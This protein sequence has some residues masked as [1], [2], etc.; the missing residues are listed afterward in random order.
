M[1]TATICP[2]CNFNHDGPVDTCQ[3]CGTIIAKYY[4]VQQKKAQEA[5]RKRLEA[6]QLEK[7]RFEQESRTNQPLHLTFED[8]LFVCGIC[9]KCGKESK[10]KKIHLTQEKTGYSFDGWGT[11][12]CN[13][14]F[15][16]ILRDDLSKS[17]IA[18]QLCTK[19]QLHVPVKAE[20]CPYCQSRIKTSIT[21]KGMAVLF[22]MIFIP[23]LWSMC[24]NPQVVP[25]QSSS[26]PAILRSDTWTNQQNLRLIRSIANSNIKDCG[27][28]EWKGDGYKYEI[29]C[30][31]D[32][33]NWYKYQIDLT[34]NTAKYIE[35]D[36]NYKP[37]TP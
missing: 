22:A 34:N 23:A 31:P 24:G 18:S 7:E 28:I 10:I 30:S 2:A 14:T 19:C 27:I 17:V 32:V 13:Y 36:L 25:P 20:I 6:E 21:A 35:A 8:A 1:K 15:N 4:I 26:Q 16:Y 29:M 33:K 9:P 12:S 11:C 5:E 37:V 3:K